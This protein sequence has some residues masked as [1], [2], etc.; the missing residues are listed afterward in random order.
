MKKYNKSTPF[1][2]LLVLSLVAT[3]LSLK[4]L[5]FNVTPS[6]GTVVQSWGKMASILGGVYQPGFV[7]E[8]DTLSNHLLCDEDKTAIEK[9][10]SRGELACNKMRDF[11]FELPPTIDVND[12]TVTIEEPLQIPTPKSYTR[13]EGRSEMDQPTVLDLEVL[14]IAADADSEGGV[15]EGPAERREE[16]VRSIAAGVTADESEAEGK[17]GPSQMNERVFF[18]TDESPASP[19]VDKQK[20]P[21][22]EL[23]RMKKLEEIKRLQDE[24]QL[25]PEWNYPEQPATSYMVQAFQARQGIEKSRRVRVIIRNNFMLLPL[26]KPRIAAND[27]INFVDVAE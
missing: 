19:K 9:E 27:S 7:A 18:S 16:A 20:K 4:A 22:A 3:Q 8:L 13:P 1:L 6:I 14:E 11:E 15:V 10:S 17:A 26:A 5:G 2:M 24:F 21:C 23:E 25:V 12:P